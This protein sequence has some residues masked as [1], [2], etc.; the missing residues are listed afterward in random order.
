MKK[1]DLQEYLSNPSRKII[2][3]D[4]K[5]VRIICTDS[6]CNYPIVG[7]VTQDDNYEYTYNFRKDGFVTSYGESDLDLFFAPKK[8]KGYINLF[9]QNIGFNTGSVFNT[10]EEAEKS[11]KGLPYYITT[12]KIE[13]EE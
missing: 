4:G 11:A 1:F 7:L 10:K 2:T 6:R 12:I 13:W 9:K 5:P 8:K 3:R